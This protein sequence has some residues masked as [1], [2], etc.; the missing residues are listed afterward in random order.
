MMKTDRQVSENELGLSGQD[1]AL[2][3]KRE[4]KSAKLSRGCENSVERCA[5]NSNMAGIWTRKQTKA[6]NPVSVSGTTRGAAR[7]FAKTE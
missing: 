7:T 6:S 4:M 3:G 2:P 1:I 5:S